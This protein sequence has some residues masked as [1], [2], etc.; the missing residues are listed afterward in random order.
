MFSN[1][2]CTYST[3]TDVKMSQTLQVWQGGNYN[4]PGDF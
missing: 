2:I 4:V 3:D 1:D